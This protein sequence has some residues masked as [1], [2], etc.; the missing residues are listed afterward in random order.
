LQ[1]GWID[2]VSPQPTKGSD[3]PTLS[4]C[5]TTTATTTT[6][7]KESKLTGV[8]QSQTHTHRH[9]RRRRFLSSSL[10]LWCTRVWGLLFFFMY[11]RPALTTDRPTDQQRE[12]LP[13]KRKLFTFFLPRETS[14]PH[15][16]FSLFYLRLEM[17]L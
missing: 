3:P 7:K 4:S 16:F 5:C 8:A 13:W 14:S 9:T 2:Y 1:S 10:C 12:Q 17:R 11:V 6:H 15:S